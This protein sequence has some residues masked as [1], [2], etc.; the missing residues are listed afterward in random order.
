MRESFSWF[1]STILVIKPGY[2]T[3]GEGWGNISKDWFKELQHECSHEL[4]GSDWLKKRLRY[5]RYSFK[6]WIRASSSLHGFSTC[7]FDIGTVNLVYRKW[8]GTLANCCSLTLTDVERRRGVKIVDQWGIISTIA[9]RNLLFLCLTDVTSIGRLHAG[10]M[11]IIM[12]RVDTVSY[13][14]ECQC[15]HQKH[16]GLSV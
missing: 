11:V 3:V 7:V 15:T 2:K 9:K 6:V 1:P 4:V 5:D 8:E 13:P 14:M 10:K 12:F 16:T